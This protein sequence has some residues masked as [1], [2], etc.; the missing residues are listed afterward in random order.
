MV[1]SEIY[2][3]V[4]APEDYKDKVVKMKG[5][6][7]VYKDDEAGKIYYACIVQ[8]A[9]AC[10]AQGVEFVPVNDKLKYPDDFPDEGDEITIKGI[11]DAYTEDQ[12]QYICLKDAVMLD[13]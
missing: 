13:E 5:Q 4:T 7:A 9:T 11:F 8:D 2:D 1:Y 6:F 3:M 10:C 12:V